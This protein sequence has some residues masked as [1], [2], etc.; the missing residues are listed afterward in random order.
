MTSSPPSC[1]FITNK[2]CPFA[3]KAWIAL[4]AAGAKYNLEQ[5]SL[6]GPGG[7][8]DWFWKLNPKG[9]VPVLVVE[10]EDL[11]LAD[12]DLILDEIQR[13]VDAKRSKLYDVM[14]NDDVNA[15]QKVQSFRNCLSEFLPIG[16][17]AVLG[18]NNDKMW[19]KLQELD[20]LIQTPYVAGEQLTVADCAGFPFLWRI[21]QE[22]G[23]VWEEHGCNNIPQWL[24]Q[25]SRQPAFAKSIQ[26]SWW[27]WW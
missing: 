7:K 12:S 27:W 23:N 14:S 10:D 22:Y 9:Q 2:M 24:E 3:Q 6:Y 19:T 16:K 5:V 18:G 8:P 17:K 21:Q 1:R 13:V 11:V 26:S 15:T 25:C 4:E 20:A